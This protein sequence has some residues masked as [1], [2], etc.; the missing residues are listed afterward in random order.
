[1][2]EPRSG[3]QRRFCPTAKSDCWW[4]RRNQIFYK[5]TE[6]YDPAK[7]SSNARRYDDARWATLPCCCLRKVLIAGGWIG[8]LH[9]LCELYDPAPV[10]SR[11]SPNDEPRGNPSAT[12]LGD[13]D[14]LIAAARP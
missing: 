14:V 9:R 6:L 8:K 10:D 5:S 7:A 3:I 2:L 11:R 13:G 1:M 12:L 4:M